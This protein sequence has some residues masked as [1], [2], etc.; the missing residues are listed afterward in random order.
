MTDQFEHLDAPARRA[1][2][3]AEEVKQSLAQ[4]RRE[5][6]HTSVVEL[7][8]RFTRL[9]LLATQLQER[10]DAALIIREGGT[11]RQILLS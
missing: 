11:E 7:L 4:L 1:P 9:G 2:T 6:Q 8:R 5:R 3:F 10:P